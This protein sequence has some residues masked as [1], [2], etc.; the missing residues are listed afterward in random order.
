M[1]NDREKQQRF[2]S[3]YEPVHQSFLRY[4]EVLTKDPEAAK[5]LVSEVVLTAYHKLDRLKQ[6]A[7][8]LYFLFG[9]ARHTYYNLLR[10]RKREVRY[11]STEHQP[12][13]CSRQPEV[14]ADVRLLYEALDKLPDKQ[15]EA[16]VLF[17]ISGF[18]LKEIQEIQGGSLS[19]VKLR[20]VRG[21]EKLKSI[22]REANTLS[23][24]A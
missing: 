14:S 2:M 4:C 9:I 6:E 23:D 11:N 15:R 18:A 19:G 17:E 3:L 10:K 21:R 8:F 1:K 12:A 22:M 7:S 5:D 20:L 16:I 13:D 24:R